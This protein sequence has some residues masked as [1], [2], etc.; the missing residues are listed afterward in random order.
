MQST[1]PPRNVISK[2]FNIYF[3][4]IH[5]QPFWLLEANCSSAFD[6]SEE[7]IYVVLALSLTYTVSDFADTDLQN[8]HFY[9]D[10]SRR[11]IM[12]KIADGTVNIRVLQALCLLALFNTICKSSV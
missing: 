5:R 2:A 12:L 6:L 10:A 7:L 4:R 3:E 9:A 11:L 1:L 8:P